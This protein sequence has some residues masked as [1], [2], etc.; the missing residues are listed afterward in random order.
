M[1]C[2]TRLKKK[3]KCIKAAFCLSVKGATTCEVH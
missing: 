2:N 3:K 1:A